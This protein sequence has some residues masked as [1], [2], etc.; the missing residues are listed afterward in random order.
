MNQMSDFENQD[1]HIKAQSYAV[2]TSSANPQG[3]R[4][5]FLTDKK[6]TL[7][8]NKFKSWSISLGAHGIPRLFRAKHKSIKLMWLIFILFSISYCLLNLYR[9]LRVYLNYEYVTQSEV[10]SEVPLEFPTITICDIN[11]FTTKQAEI[12]IEEVFQNEFNASIRNNNLSAR[13]F[14]SKLEVANKRALFFSYMPEFLDDEKRKKLGFSL[15]DT[16]VECVFN[17]KTCD[18]NDFVW[19]YSHENGNCFSFNTGFDYN[20]KT[21]GIRSS[22]RPGM[23]NGLR[24][25]FF[26]NLVDNAFSSEFETGLKIFI[27]NNTIDPMSTEGIDVSRRMNTNIVL[28]KSFSQRITS[29]YSDCMDIHLFKSDPTNN[30]I[31]VNFL[32]R[33]SKY[34]YRQKDCFDLCLQYYTQEACDCYALEFPRLNQNSTPCLNKI[35]TNCF[36]KIRDE[37]IGNPK[38][39]CISMCPLECNSMEYDYSLSYSEFTSKNYFQIISKDPYFKEKYFKNEPNLTYKDFEERSLSLNIYFSELKYLVMTQSIKMTFED[40]L[41]SIGGLLGLLIGVSF[42][43]FIEIIEVFIEVLFILFLK[44]D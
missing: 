37:L 1:E 27:S 31:L 42:L 35:K 5:K 39:K 16:L 15:N 3:I 33:E 11:P 12:L 9:L 36:N 44:H 32:E 38:L 6:K 41:A 30:L 43:S 2:D 13:E 14:L 29:P 7:I 4:G 17:L 8:K 21:T 10:I 22:T 26:Q 19:F 28:K 23:V 18:Q 40:F 20:G 34:S 25:K 24:L